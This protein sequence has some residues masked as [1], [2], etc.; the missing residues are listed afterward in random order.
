[1]EKKN[2]KFVRTE[3]ECRH[4]IPFQ[5]WAPQS[6]RHGYSPESAVFPR[7]LWHVISVSSFTSF[8]YSHYSRK[9]T[10]LQPMAGYGL[11]KIC[12]YIVRGHLGHPILQLPLSNLSVSESPLWLLPPMT[13]LLNNMYP[14]TTVVMSLKGRKIRVGMRFFMKGLQFTS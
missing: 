1:M 6:P 12:H 4:V 13:I 7:V 5:E 11:F 14:N 9:Y 8:S 10:E 3:I 2:Q